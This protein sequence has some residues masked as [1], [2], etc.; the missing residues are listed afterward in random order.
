MSKDY[1]HSMQDDTIYR[2]A[3]REKVARVDI[4]KFTS[5]NDFHDACV[6]CLLEL[7]SAHP[8]VTAEMVDS[9]VKPRHLRVISEEFYLH[10]TTGKYLPP[11]IF[12][13]TR[14]ERK[15]GK[16]IRITQGAMS[17]QYMCPFC[18]RTVESYGV[19]E[20][21]LV[22]FPYCHCG[23]DMRGEQEE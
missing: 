22:R 7:P 10:L 17:E 16:W 14:P 15:V 3:A 5:V 2:Q 8:E 20:L 9:Y 21:L 6:D 4:N 13:Q 23:A 19:E 18:H 12:Q 11:P 1:A